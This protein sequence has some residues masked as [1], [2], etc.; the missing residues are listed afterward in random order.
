MAT[1]KKWE[2]KLHQARELR[3]QGS[4]ILFDRIT[5]LVACYDDEG[6]RKW[7][8]DSE[9]DELNYLDEEVSDVAATFLTLKAVLAEFPTKEEWL[10]HNIR[11]MIATV[12]AN[13]KDAREETM[14]RPK[15][16]E[17]ALAAEA[18]CERLRSEIAQLKES[19]QIVAGAKCI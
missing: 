16:K 13:Q 17:R 14:D 9:T 3:K 18:E 11:V 1:K 4:E 5:L 6:F 10:K 19:L 7:C 15:W 8:A 2:L 12:I